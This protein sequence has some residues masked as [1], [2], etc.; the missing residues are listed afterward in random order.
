MG[1]GAS[2]A[3]GC[4]WTSKMDLEIVVMG[5]RLEAHGIFRSMAEI[6]QCMPSRSV[7]SAWGLLI[8]LLIRSDTVIRYLRTQSFCLNIYISIPP[9]RK[10]RPVFRIHIRDL[11]VARITGVPSS[12]YPSVLAPRSFPLCNVS[13]FMSD[14]LLIF[15]WRHQ[16]ASLWASSTLCSF[17]NPKCR[18]NKSW[19]SERSPSPL[20]KNDGAYQVAVI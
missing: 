6:W 15:V 11:E 16:W 9:S 10:A 14:I 18:H 1:F 2:V 19:E 20:S 5:F 8:L 3:F 12:V 13:Y 4:S 7:S 17:Q